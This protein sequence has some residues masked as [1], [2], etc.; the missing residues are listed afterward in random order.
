MR[1]GTPRRF[2]KPTLIFSRN[3]DSACRFLVGF[4]WCILPLFRA[5]GCAG[6]ARPFGVFLAPSPPLRLQRCLRIF[7]AVYRVPAG[8]HVVPIET[9]DMSSWKTILYPMGANTISLSVENYSLFTLTD[10]TPTTATMQPSNSIFLVTQPSPSWTSH[11]KACCVGSRGSPPRS[12]RVACALHG[13]SRRGGCG[14]SRPYPAT[15]PGSWRSRR[16]L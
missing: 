9:T 5:V 16:A 1:F 14:R 12:C 7:F 6:G 13:W 10:L 4:L 2:H 11:H 8:R 3:G 15:R